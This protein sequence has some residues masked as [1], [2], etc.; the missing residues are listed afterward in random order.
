MG[1]FILKLISVFTFDVVYLSNLAAI[2]KRN[3][4]SVIV[5]SFDNKH[6]YQSSRNYIL[7]RILNRIKGN[8]ILLL[9]FSVS[10]CSSNKI[11]QITKESSKSLPLCALI[12]NLADTEN[13][14]ADGIA[15]T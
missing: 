15:T 11:F 9:R 12:E 5:S 2:I 10:V 6:N 3:P 13:I 4:D 7:N 14:H 1:F 8:I